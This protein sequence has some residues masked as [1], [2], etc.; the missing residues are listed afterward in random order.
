MPAQLA[1]L[2][3][4]WTAPDGRAVLSG[5][6]ASFGQERTGIVGRNGAGKSTLLNLLAGR[7]APTG[8]S[9]HRD[10][11]VALL[12]QFAGPTADETVA[13]LFGATA[14]LALLRRA[15]AGAAEADELAV[16]DWTLEER[17]TGALAR[18]GVPVGPDTP[19]RR[20]SGG[21]RARAALAA[22]I[23][24]APD[25]LLLDEPTNDL[26]RDGRRAVQ[27]LLQ[28]WRAGAIVVS[29]DRALLDAM[30]AIVDLAPAEATRY[31]GNFDA[32]RQAKAARLAAAEHD[33]AVAEKRATDLARRAQE[34]VERQQR[35]DAA[36]HRRSAKGDLP[37]ILA[38]AR[39]DNA[40][41]TA[42]GSARLTE[43]Q[44]AGA[45]ADLAEARDRIA[46]VKPAAIALPPSGLHA[47]RRV[48]ALTDVTVGYR[49]GQPVLR[50]VS[51]AVTGPERV[52]LRGRNG[53]G[54]STLLA[55]VAGRLSPWSGRVSV[56]VRA[57]LLDQRLDLLDRERTVAENFARLNPEEDANGC[58]A[59][60]A[61]FQFRAAAADRPVAALSGGERVRT[62]LA[63]VLGN[64][65]PPPLLILD[66]PT[67]HL[68]L[69]AVEALEAG[70]AAYDGALLVVSH[71][72]A[73]L[74]ALG[75]TRRVDL[76]DLADRPR[77]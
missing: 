56:E 68:D 16:A 26:D 48:L 31:R 74:D 17:L 24:A 12:R 37:R 77:A 44:R 73:F 36:G 42:G 5:I 18:M 4:A 50:D 41:R 64:R 61:R 65:A 15:E 76:D 30:D 29:H 33:L 57:A 40:E 32:F 25:F 35:R 23:F 19:L 13:D 2:N 3:L 38:G 1:L 6:T 51:L 55:L 54:K 46:A 58:R 39:R 11:T 49:P 14:G 47:D 75:I 34:R 66:E 62:A 43:R 63:C 8:G 67:N 69:D 20:L 60:L 59:A 53:S 10:G 72:A 70:L 21:Q 71:D 27:E 28:A 7:L 52:A 45:E 22:A 9:I